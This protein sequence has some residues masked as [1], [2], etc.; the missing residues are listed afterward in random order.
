MDLNWAKVSICRPTKISYVASQ[1]CPISPP[2][3]PPPYNITLLLV[4]ETHGKHSFNPSYYQGGFMAVN[5][6][7]LIAL[8]FGLRAVKKEKKNWDCLLSI[9]LAIERNGNM[10]KQPN[11][12]S[13]ATA[14][15]SFCSIIMALFKGNDRK[16]K[17]W[18]CLLSYTKSSNI[19]HFLLV[20]IHT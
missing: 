8:G 16:M 1:A 15:I 11:N 14:F 3:P 4:R 10:L 19:K 2:S 17:N 18:D 13:K 20:I 5:R 12:S 7:H 9:M 6:E